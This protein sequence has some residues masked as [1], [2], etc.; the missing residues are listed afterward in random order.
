[1]YPFKFEW[2]KAIDIN[3]VQD[4]LDNNSYDVVAVVHA[5][6][7]TGVQNAQQLQHHKNYYLNDLELDLYL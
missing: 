1:M 3:Q 2:G 7:S 4:H 6:T 5:E